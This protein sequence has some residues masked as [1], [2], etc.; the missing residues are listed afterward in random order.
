[1]E[2]VNAINQPAFWLYFAYT[3]LVITAVLHILYQR[4]SPQNLMAWLLTLLLLPFIG[5]LLYIVLGSRKFFTKRKK[6]IL[7]IQPSFKEPPQSDLGASINNILV[8]NHLPSSS[9]NNHIETFEN[10][11]E[12]FERFML[13]LESTQSSI[14][15]QTYIF[16]LDQTGNAILQAL[17]NK[18]KQGVEVCLLMDAIGSF[19]LYRKQKKLKP[20][21]DAGGQYAF[22][23]PLLK[24]PFNSQLNLRNHRKIYLFDEKTLFTGGMNLSSD[25]LGSKNTPH[26]YWKDLLQKIEGPAVLHYQNIFNEDWKYTT[27][28]NIRHLQNIQPL[29]Q[30]ARKGGDS[31]Q[32]IPSGPDIETDVLFECLLHSLF[33]AKE[34]IEIVSPYFIPDSSL[35]NALLIAIKRGVKVTLTTPYKSDHI[36]FDLGR[37]SYMRELNE[38]GGKVFL[39]GSTMLHAKLI[40]IDDECAIIGSANLDYRSM[41]IN[42]EVVNFIYSKTVIQQMKNWLNKIQTSATVYHSSQ[43]RRRR[44]LEN[45]TRIFAP[46]L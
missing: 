7:S 8:A 2:I 12:A 44:L 17:I 22:F 33:A 32:V 43:K 28:Q 34:R 30:T 9:Q 20:L 24:S 35:M 14:Y 36:I 16:E 41:F 25:Y 19:E 26:T 23:Q 39:D 3:I 1:M 5:L 27:N 11:T 40:L 37:S 46:I 29:E 4:R 45:L 42:H 31:I 13:T 10:A 6:P 21:V 15:L 38:N 18:A